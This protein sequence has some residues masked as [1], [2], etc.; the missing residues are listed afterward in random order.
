MET[1]FFFFK[2]CFRSRAEQAAD[3]PEVPPPTP[4]VGGPSPGPA[5]NE[6]VTVKKKVQSG[7]S[8]KS[9]YPLTPPRSHLPPLAEP[10]TGRE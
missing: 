3:P 2:K 9:A 10:R 8:E 4:G 7:T 5:V 6:I 1:F